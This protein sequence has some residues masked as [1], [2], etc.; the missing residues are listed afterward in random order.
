MTTLGMGNRKG[1]SEEVALTRKMNCLEEIPGWNRGSKGIEKVWIPEQSH[2]AGA[3]YL[4]KAD[5]GV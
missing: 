1:F 3:W 2:V 4:S 5:K